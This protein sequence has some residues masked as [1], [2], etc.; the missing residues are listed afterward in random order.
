MVAVDFD[1]ARYVAERRGR[2]E[3]RARDGAAYAFSGARKVQRTLATAR[4]VAI[5]IEAT[6]RLWQGAAKDELLSASARATDETH[7][8]VRGAAVAAARAL[9]IDPPAVYVA[10][11]DAGISDATL[12]TV[13]EPYVV[14]NADLVARLSDVE[15]VALIGHHC[16][17]IQNN[18]VTY[19]TALH[20]LTRAAA[21]LVRWAV[22]PATMALQAW[23]RR[24]EITCDRAALL[25]TRDIDATFRQMVKCQASVPAGVDAM[26]ADDYLARAPDAPGTLGGIGEL[27]RSDPY[28][29]K[30]V[31]ALKLF[32][33]SAFYR[34]ITGQSGGRSAEEVDRE[35]AQL[36]SVF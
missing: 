36:L 20:Y 33:D 21:S 26:T 6:S 14:V 7:P 16:G 17:H 11:A 2:V 13:D 29:L 32:A 28:L 4:P 10:P 34:R 18:H 8:A 24:A 31:K 30:R 5:A 3:Q 22:R 23:S 9:G 27:F 15:L 25:C 35:V 1:F 12:G 19:T